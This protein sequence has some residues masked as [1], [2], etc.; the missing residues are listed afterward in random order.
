MVLKTKLLDAPTE[1]LPAVLVRLKT[2]RPSAESGAAD[3][4]VKTSV[5]A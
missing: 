2:D 5:F 1:R 4:K 3:W